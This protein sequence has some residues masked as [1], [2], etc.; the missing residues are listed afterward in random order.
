ENSAEALQFAIKNG[1]LPPELKARLLRLIKIV[2]EA[3]HAVFYEAALDPY[4]HRIDSEFGQSSSAAQRELSPQPAIIENSVILEEKNIR[5]IVVE[6]AQ[7][8][9]VDEQATL[10]LKTSLFSS[11]SGRDEPYSI[12][13]TYNKFPG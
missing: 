11:G 13:S 8:A 2:A 4:L 1:N 12:G 10:I 6:A 9:N 7:R 3:S 5:N